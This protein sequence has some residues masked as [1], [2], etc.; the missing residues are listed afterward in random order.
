MKQCYSYTETKI[1]KSDTKDNI[2]YYYKIPI[3][4]GSKKMYKIL[5]GGDPLDLDTNLMKEIRKRK[6][7]SS[8]DNYTLVSLEPYEATVYYK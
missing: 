6:D 8:S 4:N 5:V 7:W 2:L 1:L 3:M